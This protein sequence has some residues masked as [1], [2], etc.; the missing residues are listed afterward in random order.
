M[1]HIPIPSVENLKT[2]TLENEQGT[3]LEILNLGASIFRFF[4]RDKNSETVN[5]AVGPQNAEEFLMEDYLKEGKCFGASIGRYAGRISGGGF[6][7]QGNKFRIYEEDGFHLHGGLRGFQYKIWKK[8]EG[9]SGNDSSITFSCFSAA[10]EEGY[11][12]NL[13]VQVKYTLTAANNLIIE[14]TATTDQSTPVNLTNHTYYNLNGEGSVSDHFLQIH[15]EKILETREK[16]MPTGEIIELQG[17]ILNFS[18]GKKIG[19][20]FI[21]DTFILKEN[22]KEAA[23]LS[24]SETGI[25]MRVETNQPSI[26]VYAPEDL[27]RWWKY[28]T[29]ISESYPSI[30]L[31]TQNFP[32]A[33][34]HKNF[35]SSILHPG[36]EYLNR[37]VFKFRLKK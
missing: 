29:N 37:S 32:D 23:V 16:L 6:I 22:Q 1:H 7:I 31:E 21:D 15:S 3:K 33:P 14:Y 19:K 2:Y 36:E 27:P 25:E 12:G 30:C 26:V 11:P 10:G 28:S 20:D 34:N 8:V 17:I 35:P 4:F 13:E 5:I 24:S 18:E 9:S